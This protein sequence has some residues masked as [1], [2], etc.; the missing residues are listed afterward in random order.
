MSLGDWLSKV[1]RDHGMQLAAEMSAENARRFPDEPPGWA[2][3]RLVW[4]F[5]EDEK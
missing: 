2:E 4:R 5:R 3:D 1:A